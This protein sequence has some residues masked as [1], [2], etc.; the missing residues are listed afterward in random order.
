M[1]G[2]LKATITRNRY[3]NYEI[4][5]SQDLGAGYIPRHLAWGI[6][7]TLWG[8]RRKARKLFATAQ[9]RLDFEKFKETIH[10]NCR[11]TQ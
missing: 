10:P 3:G 1:S 8:A 2:E 5:V 9:T 7:H 6:T 11:S 4:D